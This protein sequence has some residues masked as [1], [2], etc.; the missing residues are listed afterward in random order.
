[1]DNNEPKQT[2]DE[3]IDKAMPDAV[4]PSQPQE[5]SPATEQPSAAKPA[6]SVPAQTQS[7]QPTDDKGFASHPKWIE[8][9][10]KYKEAREQLRRV[11]QREAQLL[12]LLDDSKKSQGSQQPQDKVQALAQKVCAKNGWNM[13]SL[14]PE[15][16][17]YVQDSVRLALGVMEENSTMFDD[18]FKPLEEMSKRMEM[19]ERLTTDERMVKG[20]A[21]EEFPNHKWEEHIQPLIAKWLKEMDEKDPERKQQFTYEDIYYRATRPLI[22]EIQESKGRQEVR[23]TVKQNA[24]PLGRGPATK[25]SEPVGKKKSFDETL[26]GILDANGVKL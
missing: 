1:M 15:Q 13:A 9:E 19:Q 18:R 23:D 12:K 17:A 10:E 24:R 6:E 14:N 8:R 21:A 25:S 16:L 5:S 26:D 4:A 22:K 11:E 20:I 3:M 7:V 2:I